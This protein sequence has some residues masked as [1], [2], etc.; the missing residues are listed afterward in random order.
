M[1]HPIGR[2]TLQDYYM[3]IRNTNKKKHWNDHTISPKSIPHFL[4]PKC[5]TSVHIGFNIG[6]IPGNI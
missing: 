1:R 3:K 4:T 2:E 5:K 6:W